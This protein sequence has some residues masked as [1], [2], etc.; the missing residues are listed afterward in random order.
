ME[1]LNNDLIGHG[2]LPAS[3]SHFTWA[4]VFSNGKSSMSNGRNRAWLVSFFDENIIQDHI[5]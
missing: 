2:N 1:N 5:F 4:T 3:S